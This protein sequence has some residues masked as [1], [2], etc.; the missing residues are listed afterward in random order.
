[1]QVL[2]A[3]LSQV[4]HKNCS[5]LIYVRSYGDILIVGGNRKYTVK[6]VGVSMK[7]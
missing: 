5:E 6:I 7:T 1:M 3:F 4:W 2:G